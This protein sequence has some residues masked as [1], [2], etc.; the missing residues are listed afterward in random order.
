MCCGGTP[1]PTEFDVDLTKCDE[2]N[3]CV[4]DG[5]GYD[6]VA[7][8]TLWNSITLEAKGNL[9]GS[10]AMTANKTKPSRIKVDGINGVKKIEFDWEGYNATKDNDNKFEVIVGTNTKT[11]TFAKSEARKTT[12]YEFNDNSATSFTIKPQDSTNAENKDNRIK[13]YSV[14]FTTY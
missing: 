2:S 7:T 12:S 3:N 5:S 13:A 6:R 10:L 4:A 14:K 1:A 9:S 11:E 8:Y